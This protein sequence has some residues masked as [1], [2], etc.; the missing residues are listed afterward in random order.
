MDTV[1]E[2][3]RLTGRR[4]DLQRQPRRPRHDHRPGERH[5][6]TEPAEE[7]EGVADFRGRDR[8]PAHRQRREPPAV[9]LE[10]RVVGEGRGAQPQRH[11]RAVGRA[12]RPRPAAHGQRV[13]RDA[14]PVRVQVVR[15]HRVAEQQLVRP[16]PVV[17]GPG[18]LPGLRTDLQ[19]QPRRPGRMLI[20]SPHQILRERHP[21][22]DPLAALE[23]VA[24]DGRRHRHAGHPRR[25]H[26]VQ[27]AVHRGRDTS[28]HRAQRAQPQGCGHRAV[29]RIAD[30]AAVQRQGV[31]RD[32]DPAQVVRRHRVS[33]PQTQRA[34]SRGV[35]RLTSRL[36]DVQRQ[37]RRP[38]H[39]HRPVESHV[40]FD[41][42]APPV[43]V[44][45]R[46]GGRPVQ[47]V[48][49]R[50]RHPAAVH[51]ETDVGCDRGVLQRRVER[52][53]ERTYRPAVQRQGVR[54]DA[55][56]VGVQVVRRHRVAEPHRS[57]VHAR[58]VV[59]RL[60]GL[61]PD[62]QRQPRRPRHDHRLGEPYVHHDLLVALE[63]VAADGPAN[64]MH[65]GHSG[66]G[67]SRSL[68]D[69]ARPRRGREDGDHSHR[70]S[71]ESHARPDCRRGM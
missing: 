9:H 17:L 39:H 46:R 28:L 71:R 3:V 41:P 54:R 14:D 18:R 53:G 1:N 38:R 65:Y 56:P 26:V 4:T 10:G 12:Q 33:E 49:R 45:D 16:N 2:E 48:H 36:T 27:T 61:R 64:H 11:V 42:L 59:V 24:A 20:L 22:F 62:G 30:P 57:R 35:V 52:A 37:P 50:R 21:R 19:R 44:A 68:L 25:R 66:H 58:V 29:A 40:D 13:R 31:R 67:L 6:H 23:G 34:R 63:G 5:P 47:T 32:A 60:T 15:R 55:D 70:A 7:V 51:L 69:A 43:G 8:H